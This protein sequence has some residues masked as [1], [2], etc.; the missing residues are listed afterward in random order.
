M[1]DSQGRR[2]FTLIELLVVIAIIAILAAILFP[3]FQRAKQAAMAKSCLSNAKQLGTA[4]VMYADDY[5]G[6]LL[7]ALVGEYASEQGAGFPNRK[8]W[9]KLLFDYHKSE[10]FYVC[11][12]LVEEAKA[13]GPVPEQDYNG[14]YGIN[15]IVCSNDSDWQGHFSHKESE[16]S[17]PTSTILLTEIKGGIWAT[18]YGLLY[19]SSLNTYA[20][21]VHMGKLNVVFIDGH[22]KTMY[23]WDTIG[24][25]VE[26]WMWSD[27]D[28][29]SEPGDRAAIAALQ[30]KFKREWLRNYPPF[31][32]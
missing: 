24:D 1:R 17:R 14:N 12:A 25:T 23:L 18:S 19:R 16:Y 9:R 28:V 26:E 30:K 11:P 13:W 32:P 2:A 3:V 5:K 29:N 7:P 15:K 8:F 27:P 21:K 22:A 31:G 20:P 10:K 6:T 4:S